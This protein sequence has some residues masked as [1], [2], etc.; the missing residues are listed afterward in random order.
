MR[1]FFR[2]YNYLNDYVESNDYEWLENRVN[3]KNKPTNEEKRT[4]DIF[5][6]IA[7]WEVRPETILPDEKAPEWHDPLSVAK[8]IAY[9]PHNSF[10][11]RADD[12]PYFNGGSY[13]LWHPQS[14]LSPQEYWQRL[15]DAGIPEWGLIGRIYFSIK[16]GQL[17]QVYAGDPGC[18]EEVME[19][20][21][22]SKERT[23]EAL[24]TYAS[25]VAQRNEE[26]RKRCF[27]G[28]FSD[29][30]KV[31]LI[32]PAVI[33]IVWL[34]LYFG[35]P[36]LGLDGYVGFDLE[37]G[38]FYIFIALMFPMALAVPDFLERWSGLHP[39]TDLKL[40]GGC[41]A[42]SQAGDTQG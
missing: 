13:E 37:S 7:S 12:G 30:A 29:L 19:G 3:R 33:F 11:G 22:I 41:Q 39:Y 36:I 31:V 1:P 6:E 40:P 21:G 8:S 23:A 34:S 24:K 9:L 28:E 2:R 14:N 16:K 20:F 27:R 42:D 17:L 32:F 5:D 38:L 26:T 35:L 18:F 10:G 15:I 4:Q 25:F